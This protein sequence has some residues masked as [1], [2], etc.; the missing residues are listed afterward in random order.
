[1]DGFNSSGGQNQDHC[2]QARERF[3]WAQYDKEC[4]KNQHLV[5][6]RIGLLIKV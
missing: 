3:I 6:S 4:I 2:A 5:D 1:M